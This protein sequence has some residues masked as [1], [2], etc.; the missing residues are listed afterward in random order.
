MVYVTDVAGIPRCCGCDVAVALFR[1]LAWELPYAIGA[2]LRTSHVAHNIQAALKKKKKRAKRKEK[3]KRK[4]LLLQNPISS[5]NNSL[6][7]E[8]KSRHS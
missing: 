5:E 6:G 4:Q 3:K 1:P 7:M 8:E 2:A